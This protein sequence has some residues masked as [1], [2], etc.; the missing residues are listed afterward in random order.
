MVLASAY[1]GGFWFFV[2]V[3][4]ERRWAAVKLGFPAVALFATLLGIATVVHWEKFSHGHVA[5]WLWAGLY[6]TAPFLVV[7]AWLANR[8][9]GP[10]GDDED[11][12]SGRSPAGPSAPSGSARWSPASLMFLSP[13]MMAPC[14]PGRSPRSP[15]GSSAPSSAW[16][17]PGSASCATRGGSPCG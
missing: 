6:F 1:L 15:A 5:F 4:R 8:G 13:A 11:R 3:L 17:A 10:P 12:A 9:R 2:C 7:A 14:G 16:A